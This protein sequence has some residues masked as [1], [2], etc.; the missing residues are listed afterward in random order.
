MKKR[1]CY[2]STV[3]LIRN[4]QYE[5]CVNKLVC[6]G[7]ILHMHIWLMRS[8]SGSRLHVFYSMEATAAELVIT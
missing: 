3:Q 1:K 5:G 4:T 2:L 8:D 6:H 7:F